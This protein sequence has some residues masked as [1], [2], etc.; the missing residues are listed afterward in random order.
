MF[1]KHW[2][3]DKGASVIILI[4]RDDGKTKQTLAYFIAE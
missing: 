4:E 3:I 1:D 2:F